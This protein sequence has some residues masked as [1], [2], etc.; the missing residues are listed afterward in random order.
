LGVAL[1]AVGIRIATQR[2]EVVL[3]VILAPIVLILA[4]A[5][6]VRVVMGIFAALQ[7]EL[8]GSV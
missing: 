5:V 3:G 7:V 1:F 2:L 6:T 4:T 8:V